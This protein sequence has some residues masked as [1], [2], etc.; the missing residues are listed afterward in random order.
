MAEFRI[1]GSEAIKKAQE[2]L[3]KF[4]TFL[5][6]RQRGLQFLKHYDRSSPLKEGR[7]ETLVGGGSQVTVTTTGWSFLVF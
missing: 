7:M 6:P 1:Y 4:N 5:I 2:N 3:K